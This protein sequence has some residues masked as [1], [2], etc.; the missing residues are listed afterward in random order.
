MITVMFTHYLNVSAITKDVAI[1]TNDLHV[2]AENA[3]AGRGSLPGF[4][5][6]ISIWTGNAEHSAM[7]AE[8]VSFN[9]YGD[10]LLRTGNSGIIDLRPIQGA[11]MKRALMKPA[12]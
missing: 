12:R 1:T 8:H 11:N 4:A 3:R 2:K 5:G 10:A 9:E 6:G 7:E